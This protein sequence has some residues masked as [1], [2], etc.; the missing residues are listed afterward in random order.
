MIFFPTVMD[1]EGVEMKLVAEP[2]A[3]RDEGESIE[4]EHCSALDD[5]ELTAHK[6]SAQR[7]QSSFRSKWNLIKK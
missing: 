4:G 5:P 1:K 3:V 6:Q 7:Q 2:V